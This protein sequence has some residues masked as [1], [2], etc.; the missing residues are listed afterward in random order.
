MFSVDFLGSR[1]NA[2]LVPKVH[3]ALHASHAALPRLR[4]NK[5][6]SLAWKRFLP[7]KYLFLGIKLLIL[8]FYRCIDLSIFLGY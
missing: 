5:L 8:S 3:V 1:A 4:Y 7:L 2:E 6:I